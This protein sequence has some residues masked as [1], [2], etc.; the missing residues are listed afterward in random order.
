MYRL[1][2]DFN[3]SSKAGVLGKKA[4]SIFNSLTKSMSVSIPFNSLPRTT[5]V[6][7]IGLIILGFALPLINRGLTSSSSLGFRLQSCA[8]LFPFRY[9]LFLWEKTRMSL[10]RS[11]IGS[12]STSGGSPNVLVLGAGVASMPGRR[13]TG[14]GCAYRLKFGYGV[15]MIR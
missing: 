7:Q 5:R 10:M 13:F 3:W 11:P 9:T 12:H 15:G 1:A 4:A 8:A 6:K 2:L 14:C